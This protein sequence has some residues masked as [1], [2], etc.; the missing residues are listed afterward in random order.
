MAAARKVSRISIGDPAVRPLS[1]TYDLPQFLTQEDRASEDLP[2]GTR[3]G[4]AIRHN[5]P[6]E[7]EYVLRIRLQRS[8]N[9]SGEPNRIVGLAEAQQLEVR[10]DGT[11]IKEFTVGGERKTRAQQAAYER[12]AD[13]GLEVRFSAKAGV[14]RIG[15]AF[16]NETSV[17]EG[18][19]RPQLAWL[20]VLTRGGVGVV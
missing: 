20:N 3:G 11:R 9:A 14:R 4:I 10:L 7:G 19:L 16:L 8:Y 5:F 12:T 15:V 6:A 13:A 2:F 18:A 1:K 17:P